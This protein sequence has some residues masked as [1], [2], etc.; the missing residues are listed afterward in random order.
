VP[1]VWRAI[2]VVTLGLRHG[3][4]GHENLAGLAPDVAAALARAADT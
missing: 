2:G 1:H 3:E 4:L